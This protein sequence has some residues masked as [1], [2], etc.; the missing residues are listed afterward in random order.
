MTRRDLRSRYRGSFA[1]AFWPVL[2]PL[3]LMAT[4]YFVFGVVLQAR[5]EGDVTRSGFVLN[6]LAG[7]LPWLAFSEAVARA[8]GALLE[9]RH[10]VKKAVFPLETVPAQ[11]VLS[12]LATQA[13]ALAIYLA[14]LTAVRGLPPPTVVLIPLLLA[15][16]ILLTLGIAWMLA[17][18]GVFVRDLIQIIGPLLTLLFFL[19]PICYPPAALSPD[20]YVIL[21]KSPIEVLVRGWRAVLLDG[22][23]PP[24]RGLF[25]AY[26]ASLAVFAL[27]IAFFTRL[28][29]D[30]ADVL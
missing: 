9:N 23:L 2:H 11:Y 5:F 16:Q 24:M 26:L 4:Y 12:A 27:G 14:I 22:T 7:M 3:I 1:E 28:R 29:R 25:G 15:P 19:T 8:P 21:R 30:F 13:F 20:I 17:G 10:L 18:L 6:F